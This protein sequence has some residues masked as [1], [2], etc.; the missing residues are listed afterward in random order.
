MESEQDRRALTDA[1]ATLGFQVESLGGYPVVDPPDN[2]DVVG[3]PPTPEA[4]AEA[5]SRYLVEHP[6]EPGRP[7]TDQEINAAVAQYC[8]VFGCTG[9]EGQTGPGPSDAQV[10]QSVSTYCAAHGGC[11]GSVG[12][13]GPQGEPGPQ[14]AQGLQGDQGPQG[15]PGS[16]P[17]S[18]TFTYL[19]IDYTCTDPD[20]DGNYTCE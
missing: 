17:A 11:R 13:G 9:P 3:V 18:F 16:P 10:A 8:F 1:V 2:P 4:V 6:P 12:P 19:G 7:P 15:D 20:A 14:G 5:V